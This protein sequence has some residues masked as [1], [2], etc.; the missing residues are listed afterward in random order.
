MAG[1]LAAIGAVATT[2]LLVSAPRP[3]ATLVKTGD[4][5]SVDALALI[6]A[7]YFFA[8]ID[9]SSLRAHEGFEGWDIFAGSN[10]FG[11]PCL[12]AIAP[13][14]DW[15]RIECTPQPAQLVADSHPYTQP[16]GPMIRFI[17]HGD[18]VE[19]WVYPHVEAGQ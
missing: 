15:V 13:T 4:L 19:A 1:A 8:R 2:V 16:D 12:V 7:E 9:G 14:D 10:A 18:V 6:E 17:L 5:P 3:D 11:A